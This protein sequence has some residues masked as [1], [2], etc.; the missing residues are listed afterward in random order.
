MQLLINF[1]LALPF[2]FLFFICPYTQFQYFIAY[3]FLILTV[4]DMQVSTGSLNMYLCQI[5]MV[6]NMFT[7]L[8]RLLPFLHL[9]LAYLFC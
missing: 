4:D 2:S 8:L 7:F 3:Y 6:I 9:Q 5:L 1:G